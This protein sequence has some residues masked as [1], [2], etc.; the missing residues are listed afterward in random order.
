MT[1]T[2][3]PPATPAGAQHRLDLGDTRASDPL[4]LAYT[5]TRLAAHG[6]P[7]EKARATPHLRLPLDRVARALAGETRD[8]RRDAT[9]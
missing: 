5:V 6:I 2:H 1:T 8:E 4:F 7:F 3:Q 9:D